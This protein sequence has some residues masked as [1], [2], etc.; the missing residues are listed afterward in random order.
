MTT[1]PLA[2]P[3][4]TIQL[5]FAHSM[6]LATSFLSL[7]LMI[8]LLLL[9]SEAVAVAVGSRAFMVLL[10]SPPGSSASRDVT[11]IHYIAYNTKTESVIIH[12]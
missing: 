6:A 7:V 5:T 3:D 4:A 12:L 8:P 2:S 11:S 1:V 9:M 10:L